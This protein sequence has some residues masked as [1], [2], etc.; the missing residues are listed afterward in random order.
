MHNNL[1]AGKATVTEV[2]RLLEYTKDYE[3]NIP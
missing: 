2:Q 1:A 3:E